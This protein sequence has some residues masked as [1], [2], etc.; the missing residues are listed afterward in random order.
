[1]PAIT[2]VYDT[3]SHADRVI[4]ELEAAGIPSSAISL[5]ASRHVSDAFANVEDAAGAGAGV[6]AALC[7]SAGLLAGL[8][9]LA[10]PG[11][12][13]VVAAGWLAATAVCAVAGAAAGGL[14]GALVA[15][16]LSENDA[17]L[18]AE[19]VRRGGTIVT[20]RTDEAAAGHAREIMDR[21]G[22]IDVSERRAEYARAGWTRFDPSAE[23]YL[24]S[25]AELERVRRPHA[26]GTP[27]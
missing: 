5:V 3:F 4:A 16:G 26:A 22:P 25:D 21:F 17:N 8:G 18:Y 10:I 14:V 2:R 19:I 24:P 13:P 20:V 9:I 27:G 1:M 15:S 7:G 23:P 11:L 12:G 6:G